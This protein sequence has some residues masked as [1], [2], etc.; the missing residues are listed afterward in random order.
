M[1]LFG[2]YISPYHIIK[3]DTWQ[4][5]IS[6]KLWLHQTNQLG[7]LMESNQ[8]TSST[9]GVEMEAKNEHGYFWFSEESYR[10]LKMITF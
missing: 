5:K 8:P 7:E 1:L 3:W 2:V 4:S 9:Q 6:K 10:D